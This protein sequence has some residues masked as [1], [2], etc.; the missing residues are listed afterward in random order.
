MN[1][2]SGD[3]LFESNLELAALLRAIAHPARLEL[4]Q[5]LQAGEECVCHLTALL[6]KRQA[7]ISQQLAS[8]READL[9][10][11]RKEGLRVYY[12]ICE[13]RLAPVLAALRSKESPVLGHAVVMSCPCPRCVSESGQ[14]KSRLTCEKR[15]GEEKNA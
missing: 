13:P 1:I 11:E 12:H 3:D 5:A 2:V 7:Y 6:G 4:L 8:L 14:G 9:I 15:E 10:A